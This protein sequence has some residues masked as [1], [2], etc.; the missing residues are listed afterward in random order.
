MS[1]VRVAVLR[2]GP[3]DEYAVS[4]Q[5]GATVLSALDRNVYTPIDVVITKDGEWLHD[6]WTK[7][8]E[9][10][11]ANVDIAFIALHGAYGEDGTLQKMLDTFG[12]RYTGS[13]A[14]PSCIAMNKVLTK[15][16]L[17]ES[18]IKLAPHMV[19]S[20]DSREH[21]H[22]LSEKIEDMF[23]PQYMIKPLASGSSIGVS[24]VKNAA[25]LP[26]ALESALEESEKVLVEQRIIGREATCGVINRFREREV[27]SLPVIEIVPPISADFFSHDVKY[28]GESDEICPARFSHDIKQEISRIASHVHQELGLSQYSRSD[29]MV[30]DDGV[31]FLEVNTLPGLTPESLFPKA[32]SAVGSTYQQFI[33]H[34]LTD[35]LEHK[36]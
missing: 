11:L 13:G 28:T 15:D 17:R 16:K 8:P 29:F 24:V 10:I 35:A 30:S 3:S 32:L 18:S 34:L 26:R 7:Y 22:K 20:R 23:G 31:Y 36:K 27:Y 4:M 9:Q 19:V 1:N 2:G 12:I 33:S 6:G 14:L 5:T 25:Y 21:T